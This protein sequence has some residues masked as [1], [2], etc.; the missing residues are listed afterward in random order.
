M[1][2]THFNIAKP[3]GQEE[4]KITGLFRHNGRLLVIHNV[5]GH[6]SYRCSDYLTG[7][8]FDNCES[9]YFKECKRFAKDKLDMNKDFDFSVLKQI[10]K[11]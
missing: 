11:L 3:D 9:S 8:C 1:R 2:K 5:D 7:M 10:N 4:V 6:I